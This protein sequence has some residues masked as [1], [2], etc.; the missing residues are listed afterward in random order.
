VAVFGRPGE[1]AAR[2]LAKGWLVAVHG[3]LAYREWGTEDGGR[4]AAHSIVGNVDFLTPPRRDG[5]GA[6]NSEAADEVVD[7]QSE[8]VPF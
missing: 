1:A 3:E 2:V 4:R 7:P 8:R 5:V 6:A